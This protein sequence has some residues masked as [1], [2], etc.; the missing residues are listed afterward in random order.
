M[1]VFKSVSLLDA[2]L[3]VLPHSAIHFF[4]QVTPSTFQP[5]PQKI[6][7]R[8]NKRYV[9]QSRLKDVFHDLNF[10][11]RSVKAET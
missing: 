9:H 7:K 1:T 6:E 8:E 2:S 5:T 11:K 4:S 3:L 10:L